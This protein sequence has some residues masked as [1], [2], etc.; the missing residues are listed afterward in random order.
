MQALVGTRKGLFV[1]DVAHGTIRHTA[2]LAEPVSA[3]LRDPRDGALYVAL[4]LGHFGAKLHRSE[5]GGVSWREIATP[6]YPE[7][8]QTTDDPLPWSVEMIWALAAGGDEQPGRLWCGTIPGGLFRS[9]DR[10][11]SWSL[12]ES[13]WLDPLRRSWDG[14]GYD[15]PGIPSICVDPRNPAHVTVGASI[16]GVYQTSDDGATWTALGEGLRADYV[17]PDIAGDP[18]Q[19]D[20]HLI[21]RCDAEPDTFWMQHHNGMWVSR[22]NA[23]TW[24]ELTD[25]S[26]SNFGFAVAVDERDPDVA[27]FVPAGKDEHR[28]PVDGRVVVTNTRDG[29]HTFRV[30]SDGLPQRHAYDLVYRHALAACRGTLVMGST[31]GS[32]WTSEDGGDHWTTLSNH[33]PPIYCVRLVDD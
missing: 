32:L 29:G 4:D 20:P 30:Q 9:D 23:R 7:K 14:G 15:H 6:A 18:E 12:V 26:P 31:T 28:V 8:P 10:G 24:T 17:P 3:L 13:L 25:V 19:Q 1:W 27:W 21:V 5:D 2:F 16:G 11:A 33:M 22:D